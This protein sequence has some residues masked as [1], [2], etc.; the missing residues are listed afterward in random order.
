[1]DPR[2]RRVLL[3]GFDSA[4]PD[5]VEQGISEGWLPHLAR[6]RVRGTYGRLRS[7]SDWLVSSHWASFSQGVPPSEHGCYHFLQWNA[8]EMALKRPDPARIVRE[9]F[10]RELTR[11]GTRVVALDVPYTHPP[12][13]GAGVELSG[14]AT[15]EL[16]F[17]PYAHPAWLGD[18]ARQTY[19]RSLRRAG[20]GLAFE[21]YAP[22]PLHE[23][24]R[25]RDQLVEVVDKAS[26]LA[27]EL[28]ERAPWDLFLTVFGAPHRAGHLLWSGSS[29]EGEAGP[30]IDRVMQGALRDV[31]VATDRAIG[32]VVEAVDDDVPVVVFSLIG[33][34][35]N[36]SR[37]DILPA[38]LAR[39]LADDPGAV[40]D[41]EK[42]GV[43][44]RLRQAIPLRWR[45]VVKARLP[46]AVQDRLS[47][48]WRSGR[49]DWSRTRAVSLTADV[50][51]Y[52]R[53]NLRGREAQG[54]VE[55]GRDRDRLCEEITEGLLGFAD[56]VTGEPV[57]AEVKRIDELFPSGQ[58]RD[59]LPDLVVR[60]AP[61]P[62]ADTRAVI[63][64]RFGS[65][66]W[67]TPGKN[68]NGR[69]GNHTAEGFVL[70]SGPGIRHGS[71][72]GA[73]RHILDLPPTILALLGKQTQPHMTGD[74]ISEIA[75]DAH[76]EMRVG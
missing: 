7:T 61:S 10:W 67:P 49:A 9:P 40:P 35:H 6:L 2:D 4:A 75:P 51:G 29:V 38:M 32:R 19:G 45:H 62:C 36:T 59:A 11:G 70:A 68:P 63:S 22:R 14:W 60:W 20:E 33:M 12:R 57:V 27:C 23:L 47:M 48:F 66:P 52:V 53:I 76:S 37:T 30:E 64:E 24:L 21:R 17:K 18:L 65:I 56:A 74:V 55:P 31:Y 54:V 3:I 73:E 46:L 72:L 50:H 39:I 42:L 71:S 43:V 25:I 8:D 58:R 69:S 16:I 28:M 44:K 34:A 1:M 5:L 41:H 13:E 15:N 26:R